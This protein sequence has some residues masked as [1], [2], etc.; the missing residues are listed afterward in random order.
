VV[1]NLLKFAR[2]SKPD[3][4]SVTA[5]SIVE[6]TLSFLKVEVG[7]AGIR[8][9]LHLQDHPR[10]I[11]VDG[12]QIKQVLINVIMNA[13]Q[14]MEE[15]RGEL[16]ITTSEASYENQ[17]M[18][19]LTVKDNGCG[20]TEDQVSHMFDPFFTTKIPGEMGSGGIGL[21]LSVTYSIIE[22]HGGAV[23]VDSEVGT[24][25]SIEIYL[26]HQPSAPDETGPLE[27]EEGEATIMTPKPVA[28]DA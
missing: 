20:M 12:N 10:V 23:R 15:T 8:I 1:N 26:P 13:I 21:G 4:E 24:G 27:D 28:F 18:C 2:P 25:T 3:K 14:A 11:P 22:Q 16:T 9:N 19:C 6:E 17:S 5:N 7:K